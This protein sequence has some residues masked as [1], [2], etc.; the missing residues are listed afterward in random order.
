MFQRLRTVAVI[1]WV[2]NV[3]RVP[4][5]AFHRFPYRRTADG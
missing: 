1:L 5:H 4:G 3:N 2:T